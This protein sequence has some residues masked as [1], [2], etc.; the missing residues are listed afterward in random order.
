MV[1]YANYTRELGAR[2]ERR[3]WKEHDFS[4]KLVEK[5]P[6]SSKKKKTLAKFLIERYIFQ[7]QE[8]KNIA[9]ANI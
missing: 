8:I 1:I 2:G 3:G 9:F 7:N 5:H 4:F 6:K